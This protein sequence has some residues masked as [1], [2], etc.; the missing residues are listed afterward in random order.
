M[1]QVEN[2]SELALFNRCYANITGTRVPFNH[3]LRASVVAGTITAINACLQVLDSARLN[4]S[5]AGGEGRLVTDS[6]QGRLVLQRFNDF[7]RTWFP[8]DN[9]GTA[10]PQGLSFNALT[11]FIY[12]QGEGGLHVTR[13]LFTPGV[14]YSDV[15]VGRYS[16]EALR[17]SGPIANA[18]NTTIGLRTPLAQATTYTNGARVNLQTELVQFGDLLGLRPINLNPAKFNL[19]VIGTHA[20]GDYPRFMQPMRTHESLGGGF[21]GT[22]SYLLMNLGRSNYSPMDGGLRVPRL[23]AKAAINTLMCRDLPVIR[24]AD[25]VPF[26]QATGIPF[27]QSTT[28]MQCHASMDRLSYT[29]RN[30]SYNTIPILSDDGNM[31]ASVWPTTEPAEVGQVTA[32]NRFHLRPTNGVLY[33][34][35]YDGRLVNE[36][37][38]SIAELGSAFAANN[39]M[40]VCAASR[41]FKFFTG[42]EVNLNDIGDTNKP[43]MTAA[44][45]K[46]RDQVIAM[47]L[48]LKTTQ[49]LRTL[50]Q[51]I[52]SSDIYRR[53]SL[54]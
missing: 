9:F 18:V 13:T 21:L 8:T 54:E 30:I 50:I 26:L 53:S 25:S 16:M 11:R 27:R 3:N 22:K 19:S 20:E 5:A 43:V 47:G 39:D 42:I 23:W 4:S 52:L 2:L 41:Y 17:T 36:P 49:N 29:A 37:V 6:P 12:D 38:R 7:H 40:Y 34:R 51:R 35:A 24:R 44:E 32:D 15:A 33:Y 46:Y 31:Q 45:I 10:L 14:N 48:E 1:A 28:C